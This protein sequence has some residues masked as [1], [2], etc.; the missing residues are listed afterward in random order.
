MDFVQSLADPY[1]YTCKEHGIMLL[2]YVDDIITVSRDAV[3]IEWFYDQLSSRFNTKNLREIS[4]IL[5][6]RIIRD[7]KSCTLTIDQEEYLDAILNKFRITHMQYHPKKIPV[8]DY[9]CLRSTNHDDELINVN[10]YQQAIGSTIHLMVY[11]RPDIAFVLGRLSQ[12]M[13]KPAKHHSIA[14]KNLIGY[15]RSTIK[16]KL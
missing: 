11:T 14:L 8:A 2:V 4:K 3:Q 5:G 15:L 16:Q 1:L 6:I 13:A 9:N 7:R 10:S 12:Y